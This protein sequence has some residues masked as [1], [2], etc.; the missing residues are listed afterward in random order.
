[1]QEE[2]PR[3]KPRIPLS[4]EEL[5]YFKKIKHLKALKQ[6]ED[7]KVTPFYK[8]TNLINSVLAGFLTYCVLSIL[9]FCNWQQSHILK[10]ESHYSEFDSETK[11]TSITE[12][13]ITTTEGE[14]IPVKTSQLFRAPKENEV[15]Y[16]GR[17][18]IFNKIMKVKLANNDR[19]FWHFYSYPSLTVCVFAL[20]FGFFVYKIN[21][22]LSI[23]GLLTVNVLFILASLYF[24]A[25]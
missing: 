23:N 18:F 1:M 12:I 6:V 7:F 16:I 22:H 3:R 11:K 25:I 13:K 19:Y 14:F 9:V 21:K 4:P 8:I 17:D 10:A 5:Y 2:Q 20:C 24:V 15:L